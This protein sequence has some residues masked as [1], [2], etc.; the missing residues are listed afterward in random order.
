MTEVL[1]LSER[2]VDEALRHG[3]LRSALAE[4][5]M[6]ITRG[7][8]DVPDRISASTAEGMLLAMPGFVEEVGLATKLV[9]LFPDNPASGGPSHQGVLLVFDPATGTP[10]AVMGAERLT[11]ARTSMSA[12]LA[13][14]LL[15]R[16]DSSVL[17]I[18]GA[19]T[20]GAGHLE[21]FSPI[22]DWEEIRIWNRTSVRAERLAAGDDRAVASAD[23]RRALDGADVVALCTHTDRPLFG[24]DD[25]PPGAHVSSVGIGREL[26]H[27]I[28]D[29]ARVVVEW[30]GVAAA[31]PPAG[32]LDLA[33]LEGGDVVEIGELL[34]GVAP[35]RTSEDELTVYKSVGHSAEDCAAG[36]VAIDS[37]RSLGIGS[38][39]EL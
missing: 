13:A 4:A 32:A 5:F 9:T 23:L 25:M 31:E 39:I 11:Q 24:D 7:S 22:R 37:A 36:R 16:P 20:Q 8:V 15:A 10:M 29:G 17:T 33:E 12:A 6:A 19:G 30:R 18:V 27:G 1:A 21:A 35:G 3:D 34:A 38:T 2:D 14:D 26:P 28:V